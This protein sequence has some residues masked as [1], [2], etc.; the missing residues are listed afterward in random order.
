MNIGLDLRPSLARPTGVGSYVQALAHRLPRLAP[1]HHFFYFSAS[2]KDRY[3][4]RDWEANVT[5]VDRRLPVQA[6]NYAW[7]RLGAPALDRLVRA[8]LDLVHSPHPLIVPGKRARHIVTVHDLFFYKHPDLTTAE[9]RRDYAP[10]VRDHV[11][12]ADGVICVSEYTAQEAHLLLEVPSH[13]IAVIPNGV[14]PAY[15]EP[16]A[17]AEVDAVLAR[18]RLPRGGLLYIG[19]EEKRKNL[20][21]LAMAYMGLARR[22]RVLPPLVLVGPGFHW[23]SGG[24]IASPRIHATGYLETREVR[25]LMAASSML[26]LPRWRRASACRWRRPWRPDCRS[27][28]RAGRP[29]KRSRAAPPPW[30][31]RSTR[32][33]SRTASSRCSTTA[34]RRGAS[35]P[36]GWSR[37]GGTTGKR[38]RDSRW[39]STAGSPGRDDGRPA[40]GRDR[41]AAADRRGRARALRPAHR[42]RPL[43]AQPD[44]GL[45]PAARGHAR[46]VLQRPAADDP[47]LRDPRVLA[48]ALRRMRPGIAWQQLRLPPAVPADGLDVFFAPAYRVRSGSTC[49]P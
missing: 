42:R 45:H 13:K 28:A 25:A 41:P 21:N 5:L 49:R 38:R 15:R 48:R 32:A 4:E 37:A 30:W 2:L 22:G 27:S 18:R 29:W 43:P 47:V 9:V 24:A 39:T 36:P 7:N 14:D 34:T 17:A 40:G 26:V 31:T 3:P 23:A 8:P 16:I 35:A 33:R 1:E 46:R 44:P 20:V 19:S 6:L 12:R 11:K 10:L